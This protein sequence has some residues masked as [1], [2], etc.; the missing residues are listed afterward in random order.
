MWNYKTAMRDMWRKISLYNKKNNNIH[1]KMTRSWLAESSVVQVN[2]T[3]DSVI[4]GQ[5]VYNTSANYISKFWIL[6]GWT[7]IEMFLSQ[8]YHVKWWRKA[9]SRVRENGFITCGSCNFSFLKNS[10]V[11]INS[12]LNEQKPYDYLVIFLRKGLSSSAV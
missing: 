6:I 11:Q 8:W 2:T 3:G 4:P 12:K 9:F 1:E 7:T 5:K 10:Q